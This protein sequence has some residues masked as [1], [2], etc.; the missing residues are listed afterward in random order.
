MPRFG[1][2]PYTSISNQYRKVLI[3]LN[4]SIPNNPGI[5]LLKTYLNE[6]ICSQKTYIKMFTATLFSSVCEMNKHFVL[7]IDSYSDIKGSKQ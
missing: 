5:P 4:M 1:V 7:T 6:N 2:I 3:K